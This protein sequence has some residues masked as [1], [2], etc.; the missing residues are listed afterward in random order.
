MKDTIY[1]K[2]IIGNIHT[3]HYL[4]K[5][6]KKDYF[7]L[8]SDIQTIYVPIKINEQIFILFN[9]GTNCFSQETIKPDETLLTSNNVL[10]FVSDLESSISILN[11]MLTMENPVVF[12]IKI[13]LYKNWFYQVD[14]KEHSNFRIILP[15]FFLKRFIELPII[16]VYT[17]NINK[18]TIIIPS[19]WKTEKNN[20]KNP[21]SHFIKNI[22]LSSG[23]LEITYD[24]F[25]LIINLGLVIKNYQKNI[26]Y[27]GWPFS[28]PDIL[29][30]RVSRDKLVYD[31]FTNEIRN[32]NEDQVLFIT[33][34]QEL[35]LKGSETFNLMQKNKKDFLICNCIVKNNPDLSNIFCYFRL[36]ISDED[37]QK[38]AE[39]LLEIERRE[40]REEQLKKWKKQEKKKKKAGIEHLKKMK[41]IAKNIA[42]EAVIFLDKQNTKKNHMIFVKSILKKIAIEATF[43][44]T[45]IKSIT[46]HKENMKTTAKILSIEAVNYLSKKK[47]ESIWLFNLW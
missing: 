3:A 18:P 46:K 34:E 27:I 47:E 25:K 35:F 37:A 13:N 6:N 26:I 12:S 17:I 8:R 11:S 42:N 21:F 2:Y 30:I 33:N 38:N 40:Q 15:I 43:Y 39:I 31:F 20:D 28:S 45:K 14:S 9:T 5:N 41:L 36:K 29:K 19:V 22:D 32:Y 44:L 7:F 24:V 1:S 4:D 16:D 23:E 10:S